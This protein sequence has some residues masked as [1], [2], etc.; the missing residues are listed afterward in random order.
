MDPGTETQIIKESDSRALRKSRT[1]ENPDH[2]QQ[3][4]HN[5]IF[6]QRQKRENKDHI[7]IKKKTNGFSKS[8]LILESLYF[9]VKRHYFNTDN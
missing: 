9:R 1:T 6:E 5:T 2:F 8:P 7:L 4:N 3:N